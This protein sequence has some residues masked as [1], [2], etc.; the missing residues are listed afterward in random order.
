M[1]YIPYSG[2]G[3]TNA[4]FDFLFTLSTI[5]LGLKLIRKYMIYKDKKLV[6][7]G[8]AWILMSS[9]WWA[10]SSNFITT[11]F[12]HYSLDP[13]IYIFLNNQFPSL[14]IIFWAYSFA[15][16]Y[17]K[18]KFK[19]IF[20]PFFIVFFSLFITT[21]VILIIN[22]YLVLSYKGI[23][24][25]YIDD[26]AALY[27]LTIISLLIRVLCIIAF[28]IT[29]ILFFKQCLKSEFKRARLKGKFFASGLLIFMIGVFLFILVPSF[30][31]TLGIQI[32]IRIG[33]I[34]SSLF[35]YLG[36]YLPEKIEKIFIKE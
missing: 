10:S 6:T 2:V 26:S 25:S 24:V 16:L 35:F 22:P 33:M 29:S 5:I 21:L 20:Y 28:L 18:E 8:L 14:S 19:Q 12:F 7:V 32:I 36:F 11:V 4:L 3:L 13:N 31:G 34:I 17:N 23:T 27:D 9:P 30:K 1:T 15:Y